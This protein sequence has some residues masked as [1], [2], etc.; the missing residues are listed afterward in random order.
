VLVV[1]VA[2]TKRWEVC[3]ASRVAP[4]YRDIEA[5]TAPSRDTVWAGTLATGDVMTI[6]RGFWHQAT[7]DGHDTG[8][9]SLH[10]T[11]GLAPRTGIDWVHYLADLAREQHLFR[12]NLSARA[13]DHQVLAEAITAL[14]KTHS[15]AEYLA[16]RHVQQPP[17]RR[18]VT[19]GAFGPPA[20]VVCVTDF[21]PRIDTSDGHAVVVTAAGR[22]LTFAR[23]AL[24][25]L[26]MLLCGHPAKLTEISELTGVD[27][28]LL[29]QV[30]LEEELCAEMTEAL[31][32]AWSWAYTGP[33]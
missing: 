16:D 3:G 1:Q 13:A 12:R 22:R 6:P 17:V 24:P 29:A 18:V 21:P 26:T 31:T 7:R 9:Y 27:A 20:A 19:G 2:G 14:A 5:N 11:F 30:P 25:A 28:G 23:K 4:L 32:Q 10:V 8:G 15:P 33:G